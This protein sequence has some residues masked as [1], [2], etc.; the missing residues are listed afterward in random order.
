MEKE[1]KDSLRTAGKFSALGIQMG[2]CVGIGVY[3]GWVVDGNFDTEPWG[4]TTGAFLGI[5]A[6][7]TS[8]YRVYL[9]LKKLGDEEDGQ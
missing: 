4:I 1:I 5:A 6:A 7:A 9:T 8:L 3:L 2:L